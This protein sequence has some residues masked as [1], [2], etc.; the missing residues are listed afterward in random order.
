MDE[1][2]GLPDRDALIAMRAMLRSTL[3]VLETS[4]RSQ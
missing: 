4:L 3:P 2:T 1:W